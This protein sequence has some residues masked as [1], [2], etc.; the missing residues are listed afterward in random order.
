MNFICNIC[1]L[2]K[3]EI[4]LHRFFKHIVNKILV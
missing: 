4:T 3:K 1:Q 2:D